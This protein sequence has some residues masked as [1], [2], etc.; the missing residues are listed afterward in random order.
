VEWFNNAGWK[1]WN[2]SEELGKKKIKGSAKS[3]L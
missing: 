1:R 3:Y 2:A